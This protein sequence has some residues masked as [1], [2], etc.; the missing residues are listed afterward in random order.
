MKAGAYPLQRAGAFAGYL[1]NKSNRMSRLLA[2]E[3]M[4]YLEKVSGMWAGNRRHYSENEAVL[5][6]DR[7]V[8]PEDEEANVGHGDRF[9]AHFA[10]PETEKLQATYF[11]FLH[12]VLPL[13][14][15]IYISNRKFCF[16]SLLPGTK[17]KLILPLKDIENVDKEKGFRFGYHGL[18]LLIRGHE[19]LFFEFNSAEHRDD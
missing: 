19:E 11:G 6:D 16:R 15:K 14:G 9:R 18:V 8:D 2:T 13:Y 4:S 17:T 10:L 7:D 5:P 3:S 1:K 12:R